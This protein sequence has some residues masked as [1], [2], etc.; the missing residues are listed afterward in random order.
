[1]EFLKGVR[2]MNS[3]KLQ[4]AINILKNTKVP[5][6]RGSYHQIVEI[7]RQYKDGFC[8]LGILIENMGEEKFNITLTKKLEQIFDIDPLLWDLIADLNDNEHKTFKEI[9]EILQS[10]NDK[11]VIEQ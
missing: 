5:Q 1:M 7:D 9:A 4:K 10:V 11:E 6:V 3:L 2:K 8:A